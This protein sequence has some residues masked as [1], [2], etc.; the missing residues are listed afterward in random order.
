MTRCSGFA[1]LAAMLALAAVAHAAPDSVKVAQGQLHGAVTGSVASFKGV[2]FAAP[3]LGDLR[4]RPPQAPKAWTGTREATAFGPVCMQ[5][6]QARS[7]GTQT[8][9]EDCL[10]LNVWTP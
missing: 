9:S 2:P 10:T 1:V 3:P 5:M 4:W 7:G 6:G 8:Q